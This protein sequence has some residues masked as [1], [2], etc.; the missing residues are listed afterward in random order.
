MARPTVVKRGQLHR[1]NDRLV[2]FQHDIISTPKNLLLWIGGLGDNL[3][4]TPYPST[5]VEHLAKG[6]SLVEVSISSSLN[7]WGTGS[8][9][10]DAEEL[11][12]CVSYF[13]KL[14]GADRK[15]VLMGHSTGCQD[16]MQYVSGSVKL[17]PLDGVIL[18]APVSDREGLETGVPDDALQQVT[19]IAQKYLSNGQG[20]QVLPTN[21]SGRLFGSTP[22]SAYRALSLLS[23]NKDGDE[24]F[25]SS[26]LSDSDFEK[27]F[28]KFTSTPLLILCS[29]NDEHVPPHVDVQGLIQRWSAIVEKCGGW[30]DRENGGIV[31]RASHNL[32]DDHEG[33]ILELCRRVRGFLGVIESRTDP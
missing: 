8:V 29:G 9:L 12:E 26:D 3:L 27:T 14:C 22:M 13:R 32:A 17:P 19:E 21:L 7:G 5:L 6:W 24:D 11:G 28:G 4:S 18:Q 2:A 31:E 15:I 30:V 20:S 33:V 16:A 23:P 10:R 1:Y 25:F